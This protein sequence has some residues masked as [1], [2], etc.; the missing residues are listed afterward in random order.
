MISIV[1]ISKDEASLD[2]TLTAVAAQA[3]ALEETAEIV[4]VDASDGR[5]DY[6]RLR[7]RKQGA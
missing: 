7:H 3:Q 2:G 6:I 1:I 4:V 5:L